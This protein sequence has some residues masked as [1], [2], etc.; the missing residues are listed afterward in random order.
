MRP[1]TPSWTCAAWSSMWVPL[2]RCLGEGPGYGV[3][4]H[5]TSSLSSLFEFPM[6]MGPC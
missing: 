6:S 3:L 5:R 2:H 4:L 1:P